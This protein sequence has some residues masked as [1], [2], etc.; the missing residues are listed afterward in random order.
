MV[1]VC[2]SVEISVHHMQLHCEQLCIHASLSAFYVSWQCVVF[3]PF[4]HYFL[5]ASG[6]LRYL[7]KNAAVSSVWTLLAHIGTRNIGQLTVPLVLYPVFR[8]VLAMFMDRKAEDVLRLEQRQKE[9]AQLERIEQMLT[10]KFQALAD[11]RS[12][13]ERRVPDIQNAA[14]GQ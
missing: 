2:V 5:K 13:L 14:I 1:L 12:V 8:E 10:N 6:S 9:T 4:F 11:K 3:L 7:Q